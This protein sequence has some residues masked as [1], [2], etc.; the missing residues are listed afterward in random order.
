MRRGPRYR[1]A[2]PVEAGMPCRL[3]T[4]NGTKFFLRIY[5]GEDCPSSCGE[6]HPGYH[7]AQ[8]P[9]AESDKLKDWDAHGKPED[10]AEDRWPVK[11]DHCPAVAPVFD[12]EK[13]R[14]TGLHRQVF[15]QRRYNTASGRPE[16]G[17]MFYADWYHRDNGSCYW[18]DNCT[19]PHLMV[20]LPNGHIWD[21][22]SRASN[23]T[24]KKDRLHRCWV[25]HG[26]PPNV[27]VDKAGHTCAA[28][29]GSIAVP[30]WHG[31]LT[32]GRLV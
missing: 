22:S 31:F 7:N 10:Y 3:I 17:D 28:G 30:G 21:S 14:G 8:V 13:A 20:I 6:P 4:E 5:W 15:R 12:P 29:A 23:C 2:P 1:P 16:P 9:L 24:L 19:E 32:N 18:W 27:T 26:E 11:C 25:R